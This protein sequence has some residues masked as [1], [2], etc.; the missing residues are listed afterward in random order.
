[1]N[2]SN[3]RASKLI[4]LLRSLARRMKLRRAD[5]RSASPARSLGI[6]K[7]AE[8]S[9]GDPCPNWLIAWTSGS[10]IR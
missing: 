7:R 8:T 2:L 10:A 9:N 4:E 5:Q 6:A 1:M 3:P